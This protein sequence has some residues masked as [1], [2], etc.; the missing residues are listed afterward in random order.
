MIMMPMTV[1]HNMLKVGKP[2]MILCSNGAT[3]NKAK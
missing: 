3:D 2:G 1:R